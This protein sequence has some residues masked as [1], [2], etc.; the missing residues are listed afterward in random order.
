MNTTGSKVSSNRMNTRMKG[1][2]RQTTV[3]TCAFCG[4]RGRDPFGLLSPL[5]TCQ[6]CGSVGKHTLLLP[7]AACAYCRGT[8]VHP[9]SRLTCTS[10]KGVGMV[11][12]PA[13]AVACPACIGTGRRAVASIWPDSPLSCGYCRGKGLVSKV[14]AVLFEVEQH[15]NRRRKT[16]STGGRSPSK[17]RRARVGAH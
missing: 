2:K 8:G 4:G 11:H 14:Q 13:G 5:A 1:K 17:R 15:G 7:I 10:C 3:V 12:V 9:H 16:I 6:V